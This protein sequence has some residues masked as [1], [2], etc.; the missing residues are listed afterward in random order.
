MTLLLISITVLATLLLRAGRAQAHCDTL[1]G[2]VVKAALK[3]FEKGD[4]T[5]VL[6]WI[7]QENEA[8][9]KK[10]FDLALKVR[11]LGVCRS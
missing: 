5:P 10:A 4:V 11:A 1:E 7:Q 9:V 2:P 6:M 3:A 8:E